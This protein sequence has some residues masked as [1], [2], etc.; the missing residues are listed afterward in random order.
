MVGRILEAHGPEAA[1]EVGE[2]A[3][4]WTL[5]EELLA[6]LEEAAAALSDAAWLER[7]RALRADATKARA[8]L[9]DSTR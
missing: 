1:L 5:H 8:A 7:V 6:R 4:E 3:L 9:E 2:P